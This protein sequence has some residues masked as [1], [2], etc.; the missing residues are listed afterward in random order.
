[1][2]KHL[3]LVKHSLPKVEKNLPANKWK[4]S[5]EGQARARR[6]AERLIGF[7][8][9]VIISSH[10][11]KAVETAEIVA[12]ILQLELHIVDDLHEH[13]RSNLPYLS[14]DEFQASIQ[15]YFQKPSVLIFGEET[16]DESH[17]RFY[18][19]VHTILK[20]HTNKT[21]VIVAHGTVISLF[22]SRLTGISDL[23]L[24]NELN[25]PSFVAID[26][27]SNT[28]IAKENIV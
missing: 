22:V 14:Q 25:L 20:D 12:N 23:L 10:E 7:Y 5:E 8:P 27:Q 3:I 6:L 1:M 15:E 21:V 19:A 2:K 9:D 18:R 26:L 16:A 13:D 24:W 4:L 17:T 11:P 28:L